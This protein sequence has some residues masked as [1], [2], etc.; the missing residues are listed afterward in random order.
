MVACGT[1]DA[2]TRLLVVR[3]ALECI[4]YQQDNS[5]LVRTYCILI[6]YQALC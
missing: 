5:I 3:S 2:G 4:E 6:L 1:L